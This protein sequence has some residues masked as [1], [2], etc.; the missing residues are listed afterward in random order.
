MK[1]ITWILLP[2]LTLG[3]AARP[4]AD[5]PRRADGAAGCAA[6]SPA[7]VT[8]NADEAKALVFQVE[9]ERMARELYTELAARWDT[10]QFH[11]ILQAETRHEQ[12]LRALAQRAGVALPAAQPGRFTDPVLQQRYDTLRARGLVSAAEALAAGAAVEKQDIADL[13]A[14]LGATQSEAL[15]AVATN[16]E[17]ASERHLAAFTGEGGRGRS[18]WASRSGGACGGRAQAGCRA[19]I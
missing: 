16:L 8:L 12:A 14:L 19:R 13:Q 1:T 7:P 3:A 6:T 11:R 2:V 15:K 18:A 4:T 10:T 9:E 5:C 17:R